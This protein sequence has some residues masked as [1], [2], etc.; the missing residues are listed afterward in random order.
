VYLYCAL[1]D[2]MLGALRH[3]S[4]SFTC[5]LHQ[6]IVYKMWCLGFFPNSLLLHWL[7]H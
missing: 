4:H 6:L 1:S 2:L 7:T 3:G 5:K